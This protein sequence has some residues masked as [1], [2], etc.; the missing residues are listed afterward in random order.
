MQ[1]V[2]L[3]CARGLIRLL[4]TERFYFFYNRYRLLRDGQDSVQPPPVSAGA[5]S[6]GRKESLHVNFGK[7]S[8]LLPFLRRNIAPCPHNSEVPSVSIIILNRN[9]VDY[10]KRLFP[11]L[12][13]HTMYPR[14]EIILVDNASSDTSCAWAEGYGFAELTVIRLDK[15]YSFS[16]ANNIGARRAKGDYLVFLNNDTEV[17]YGWLAEAMR[18]FERFPKAACVGSTLVYAE[19][20]SLDKGGDWVL[21]GLS[22]QHAG[23]AFRYEGDFLRPFNVGKYRHPLHLDR[24]AKAVPAVSAA[25]QV[26]KRQLFDEIGGFDEGYFYGYEDVDICLKAREAGYEVI[27]C[28]TSVVIHH[29]FG[30]QKRVESTEKQQ[31]RL[32]NMAHFS[33]RWYDGLRRDFWREKLFGLPFLAESG[34]TIAITVTEYHPLTTCGDYFSAVGLGNALESLGYRVVYLPRRPVDEWRDVPDDIDVLLV[35][36]DDFPLDRARLR[37]GIITVAWIR[38]WVDRWSQRPW[39]Q[40]Y[41]MVLASSTTSLQTIAPRLR[42]EQYQGVLRIAADPDLFHPQTVDDR[43]AS[44]LCFVG[45]MF[46][47]PRDIAANLNLKKDWRFR[48]WGRL[49]SPGHPFAPYHEGRVS[50]Y[51]V[52]AIYNSARIVLEDCTPMCKPWGCINSRTFEA[53]ACGACVVSNDVPELRELFADAILIYRN[54]Q[55]LDEL[56]TYYLE[57]DDERRAIGAKAAAMIREKHTYAR[58]AEE[59]RT[60]LAVCLRIES[61]EPDSAVTVTL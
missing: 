13:A 23:C 6:I 43:Y 9:G 4:G 35:M 54:R 48:Y 57:H 26:W 38:N 10:L 19:I 25:C 50:Y 3:L 18:C 1:Q 52:P 7:R 14:F 53:M 36:M 21:P 32:R 58:R 59:F 39:L 2:K 28:P 37:Q 45:N 40:N 11:T 55:E 49:E 12:Q 29:E 56:L 16:A 47:V 8:D 33:A 44:D 22:V 60:H 24:V 17:C 15:N 42:P 31:N 5:S 46:H 30:T 34:L 41:D 61:H 27:H 51:E 20:S